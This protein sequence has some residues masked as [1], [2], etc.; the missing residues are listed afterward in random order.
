MHG[1][2]SLWTA[3]LVLLLLVQNAYSLNERELDCRMRHLAVRYARHLLHPWHHANDPLYCEIEDALRLKDLCP[4]LVEEDGHNITSKK[5]RGL[6]MQPPSSF[7]N[8]DEE[9]DYD[10]SSQ[11]SACRSELCLYVDANTLTSG[12]G[13]IASP[14]KSLEEAISLSRAQTRGASLGYNTTIILRQGI[15]TLE[16]T[17]Q[18]RSEDSGLTLTGYPGEEVWLSGGAAIPDDIPW[19][20]DCKVNLYVRVANLTDLLSGRTLPS[21]PSLF[22]LEKRLIRARYPNSDPEVAQWGYASPDRLKYSIPAE[23]VLEWHRPPIGEIPQFE[24]FD[25]RYHDPPKNDSSMDEYNVY[26]SGSGGVCADLWGHEAGSYW[27]SN[28]SAGGWSEVD[29]EC[30]VT[31][32]LQIPI[33]MDY[34]QSSDKGRRLDKWGTSAVGGIVHAWHSQSWAMH[35]FLIKSSSPG[36]FKFS[37]GGFQGGR[38]WCRCDQCTYAAHWCGQ[39]Q[40]PPYNDTRLISGTWL[41]ENI[42]TELDQPGEFFFDPSTK[43]LYLYPNSTKTDHTGLKNLRFAL[44]ETLIELKGAKD[45]KISKLGFRDSAA[46]YMNEWSVPSGGDWSLHRGG[47]IYIEDSSNVTI[48]NCTFRRLDGNAVFLSKKTREISIRRNMFE[49]LGESAV[50]TWGSTD[51]FDATSEDHPIG[52]LVEEN[53]MR[54]LGIYEKQSS[55]VGQNK[56]AK[57]VIRSNVMFNMPRSAINFNDMLGGGDLIENNLIFNTCRESGDHGPI[58]T[59]DRQP[60]LSKLR[61]G[62][63]SFVPLKRTI[64]SNFIIA[65]YGASSGVDNDDGSSWYHIKNNVFHSAAGFKMDYGGHDSIFEDNLVISY[66]NRDQRCINFGDFRP[67]HGHIVRRN[68]CLVPKSGVIIALEKCHQSNANL[69]DNRYFTPD[70]SATVECSYGA[71]PLSFDVVQH[72]YGLEVGSTVQRTPESAHKVASW[73]ASKLFGNQSVLERLQGSQTKVHTKQR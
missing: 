65:N 70:G 48:E 9:N 13:S 59:W 12:D 67:G 35:M 22:S 50:A 18:L 53:V 14:V 64:A 51:A 49:W 63:P 1:G 47:A 16:S 58:N 23:E 56:A 6:G 11:V 62:T 42:L 7:H 34:N 17:I 36:S 57:T 72:L 20:W 25:L 39:H 30:A 19:S 41:V 60:F 31:G 43:L 54:E 37:K 27:C 44:L 45:V 32:Q 73:A 40:D 66:G 29:R 28:A 33:G 21:V 52:T 5:L 3:F 4:D 71:E 26:A 69:H 46:T 24:Y 55:G 61:D 10:S 15:H 2:T 68:T 38:N 8:K